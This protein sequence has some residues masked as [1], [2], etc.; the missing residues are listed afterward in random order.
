[1]N[2]KNLF[3]LLLITFFQVSSQTK[4]K[5]LTGLE[6]EIDS[7]MKA[8]RLVGL[9]VAIVENDQVI[10]SKGFGYRDLENKLP[11]T[12]NT[13]FSIGS[14]TKQFTSSLIGIYEGQGKLSLE[15]K[16]SKHIIG[17]KFYN[18]EMNNSITIEELLTHQSGIGVVDGADVYFPKGS[19]Q[20]HFQRLPYLVPNGRRNRFHYSNMG[21]SILGGV[22][23]SVTKKT[24]AE[25]IQN[26][27]FI[28]LN[29][30]RSN[31]SLKEFLNTNE[32]SYGY[33]VSNDTAI[34]VLPQDQQE[35]SPAGALN[36]SANDMS[37]WLR[38]LLNK[39]K[40]HKKQVIPQSYLERAFSTQL[41]ISPGFLFEDTRDLRINTYGYGWFVGNYQNNYRVSHGGN[42]SGFSA[43]V[44]FYPTRKFGIVILS[45]QNNSGIIYNI[46]ELITNRLLE[47][48]GRKWNDFEVNI[49]PAKVF[50]TTV[51]P[52]NQKQ[53]P[54]HS[55]SAYCGKYE[56]KGYGIIE[57]ILKNGNLLAIFPVFQTVLEHHE[58]DTFY[59]KQIQRTHENNPSFD[60]TFLMNDSGEVSGMSINMQSP[61][62][63]F[64]KLK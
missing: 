2:K 12:P 27:I 6:T 39:G 55:L 32:I 41:I 22:G 44:D 63:R 59:V 30:S 53:K 9:S 3:F 45:N 64:V 7:L 10:Y 47:I 24:W 15:D 16:P 1:M 13:L 62:V 29:M 25:N 57:V 51:N 40:F 14:V 49:F 26:D 46:S 50:G 5:R 42:V 35:A 36:S 58:N 21:Y 34:R 54:S 11:V 61:V 8:Y 17:L 18:E 28:P 52:I 60:Y 20:K 23:E 37:N 38:M 56:N 43:L 48:K 4:D 19:L 31:T 33:S